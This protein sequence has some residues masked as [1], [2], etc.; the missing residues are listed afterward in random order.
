MKWE[1]YETWL[2]HAVHRNQ[3]WLFWG[4]FAAIVFLTSVGV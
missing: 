1:Q 2:R 4:A 3:T